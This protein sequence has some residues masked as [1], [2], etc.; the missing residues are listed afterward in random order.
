MQKLETWFELKKL[1]NCNHGQSIESSKFHHFDFNVASKLVTLN[2]VICFF[3]INF[4]SFLN[5][6]TL[7]N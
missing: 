5:N 4:I 1:K 3:F 2:K 7:R 6:Y